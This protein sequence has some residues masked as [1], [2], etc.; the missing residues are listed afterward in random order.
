[1][2]SLGGVSGEMCELESQG[3]PCTHCGVS[4]SPQPSVSSLKDGKH[5]ADQKGVSGLPW[6]P[7]G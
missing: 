7:S 4:E 5:Q 2:Y 3:Q 6:N 1:M